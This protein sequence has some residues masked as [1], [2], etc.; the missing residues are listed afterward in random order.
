MKQVSKLYTSN[1]LPPMHTFSF[2]ALSKHFATLFFC[3]ISVFYFQISMAQAVVEEGTYDLQF[4]EFSQGC[5]SGNTDYCVQLQIK[6]ASD[7]ESFAIGSYTFYFTYNEDA[8]NNPTYQAF[9]FGDNGTCAS[10][11]P[12]YMTSAFFADTFT[13]EANVTTIMELPNQG[14]PIVS[15][16]WISIGLVC[17]DVID[18]AETTQ[19]A[20]G[21]GFTEVNKNDDTPRHN[22]GTFSELDETP[23]VTNIPANVDLV[24][25]AP[26]TPSI[27]SDEAY[28]LIADVS[29]LAFGPQ[30]G[31]NPIVAWVIS[32]TDPED[33]SPLLAEGYTEQFL[34]GN[35]TTTTAI[36][37]GTNDGLDPFGLNVSTIWVSPITAIN[38]DESEALLEIDFTCFDWGEP[39]E[40]TFLADN[41]GDCPSTCTANVD[42]SNQMGQEI[43]I[44]SDESVDLMADLNTLD[45]GENIGENPVVGWA[46]LT[47]VPTGDLP[48]DDPNYTESIIAGDPETTVVTIGGTNDGLDPFGFDVNT[49]YFVPVTFINYDP[50]ASPSLIFDGNCLDW[51]AAIA[52]SFQPDGASDCP[53]ICE[54]NVEVA[55][56]VE[57]EVSL[58]PEESHVLRINAMSLN[59]GIEVGANPTV[60][61]VM[62]TT[63]PGEESPF[64]AE[65][66]TG[67]AIAGNDTDENITVNGTTEGTDPY[68]VGVSTLWFTPVTYFNY[69]EDNNSFDLNDNCF[70]WGEGVQVTFVA[71]GEGECVPEPQCPTATGDFSNAEDICSGDRPTVPSDEDI[72]NS[73]DD[74]SNAVINWSIDPNAPLVYEGDGCDPQ[75]VE[76]IL[77]ITCSQDETVNIVAGGFTINLYPTPQ[78]PTVIFEDAEL[79]S[80]TIVPNCPNDAVLPNEV[81]NQ[82][83]GTSGI[84]QTFTVSNAGCPALA[85]ENIAIPDCEE[86][87]PQCPSIVG[88][89]T[90]FQEICN[91]GLANIPSDEAILE[92]LDDATN[93][94]V[95]WSVDPTAPINYE[96]DGCEPQ[97]ID[98]ELTI[99]CSDNEN[100]A[101]SGGIHTVFVYPT[102]QAPSV[103]L[104]SAT[105]TCRYELIPNCE[106]DILEPNEIDNQVAGTDE[107]VQI[108]KVSNE[109]CTGLNFFDVTIPACPAICPSSAG[110]FD[111]SESLCDGDIPTVTDDAAILATVDLPEGATINWS[112]DPTDA[113][114]Y[115]G[116]GCN[117]QA[118]IFSLTIGC[119]VDG[120][121]AIPAG[122]HIVN[123]YPNPQTPIIELTDNT[124]EDCSYILVLG[125]EDDVAQAETIPPMPTDETVLIS[126][127]N[128]NG[129]EVI[130]PEVEVPNC[131]IDNIDPIQFPNQL[132][133]EIMPNFLQL[134]TLSQIEI[135]LP[136][137]SYTVLEVLDISGRRVAEIQKGKVIAGIHNFEWMP[138]N[139]T[140]G[141]YLIHLQTE[142]GSEV[143]KVVIGN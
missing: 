84:I 118:V 75:T 67:F 24:P 98:F 141:L 120:S 58:C 39:V 74:S 13:G 23:T 63:D 86:I 82:V 47:D 22:Q 25:E 44:C 113:L 133:M 11:S 96:G 134:G 131:I 31:E 4:N 33:A 77:T 97:R 90:G 85:F 126:V 52:V 110:S 18:D 121:I 65:G 32:T 137:S 92:S 2:S 34:A 43:G 104:I 26:T 45:F 41:T 130:F 70:D 28:S 36:I 105:E 142:Y 109:T 69:D 100:I 66:F 17:F 56:G 49:L 125:C 57:L 16:E 12:A 81:E 143:R 64:A 50:D 53:P 89:F 40:I 95:V 54:A 78:A 93:A 112:P 19:L 15:A 116:D 1:Y 124:G 46:I 94:I 114:V 10:G 135:Y 91:V 48:F 72:L 37:G 88:N 42:L 115:D 119:Q 122:S 20:F 128:A 38:Y 59:F 30:V 132:Q 140:N 29:T 5:G 7:V 8:I 79:C 6:S 9:N 51:G 21:T 117:P 3:F 73:L 106:N 111:T 103:N 108:I 123:L 80:Y 139:L 107:L 127:S 55:D 61:W 87:P 35:P 102:P 68:G 99:L 129:C 14:C 138:E 71:D 83:P 136:Q 27:C 62:S 60:G 76:I 101:L